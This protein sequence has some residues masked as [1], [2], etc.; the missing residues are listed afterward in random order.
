MRLSTV[1]GAG[2]QV[3]PKSASADAKKKPRWQV[4]PPFVVFKT[5]PIISALPGLV[6]PIPDNAEL[7]LVRCVRRVGAC[8]RGACVRSAFVRLCVAGVS[9]CCVREFARGSMRVRV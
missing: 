3:R 8:V 7:M 6:R 1:A 5:D 9:A 4:K 2:M